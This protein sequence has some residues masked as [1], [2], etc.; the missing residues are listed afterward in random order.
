MSAAFRFRGCAFLD[1]RVS[2]EKL[3]LAGGASQKSLSA[4]LASL[5][6]LALTRLSIGGRCFWGG[7]ALRTHGL[8]F[9]CRGPEKYS[10][11]GSHRCLGAVMDVAITVCAAVSELSRAAG[12]LT[13]RRVRAGGGIGHEIMGHNDGVL[14]FSY[15]GGEPGPSSSSR[16]ERL[17]LA[18]MARFH[19]VCVLIG[20][21]WAPSA[22]C[23]RFPSRARA[24]LF[25]GRGKAC[26]CFLP[27]GAFC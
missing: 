14:L 20:S 22:S 24:A 9:S 15:L 23:W 8:L 2:R 19:A 3:F 16:S 12:P 11:R 25:L 5:I 13:R 1:R 4:S 10:S 7:T 21:W 26:C 17:T 27:L 18:R 6:K